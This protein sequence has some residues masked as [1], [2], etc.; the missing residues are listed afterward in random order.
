MDG[1]WPVSEHE[2]LFDS[3]EVSPAELAAL[4]HAEPLSV[5]DVL[6]ILAS[7]D[8]GGALLRDPT[9][10]DLTDGKATYPRRGQAQLLLPRR[11]HDYFTDRLR[12]PA[13]VGTDDPFL[14]YFL[15]A[16]IKQSGEINASSSDIHYRRHLY[17]LHSFLKAAQGTILD[18][19]CGD[20]SVSTSLLPPR[21]RYLGLD[22]FCFEESS[23]RLI[24]VAEYL[25]VK[26]SC[27]DGVLFNTSLDHILDWRRALDEADRVLVPGGM[28]YI[29]TLAW[30]SHADL[31]HDTVHFHHFRE[32]EILGAL[33]NFTIQDVRRYDYKGNSH[34][35]GLYLSAKKVEK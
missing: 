19:G 4:P 25:P 17:R 3:N 24:G 30:S 28:L 27:L 9:S 8:T 20:P 1:G 12:V 29:C 32:Y 16:S 2:L 7:P 22:P 5:Q 15:L 18:V 14:Q 35:Y 10:G 6:P 13:S 31:I 34:R 26:P 23:F 33:R 21:T 11:L